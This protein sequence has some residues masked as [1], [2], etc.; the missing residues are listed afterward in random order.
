MLLPAVPTGQDSLKY[1]FGR[2]VLN[3]Y[4]EI[5]DIGRYLRV[6]QEIAE[7]QPFDSFVVESLRI[8]ICFREAVDDLLNILLFSRRLDG[9][10]DLLELV[11]LSL[12]VIPE[13]SNGYN[14]NK[15][16]RHKTYHDIS[17]LLL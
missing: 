14:E 4:L 13:S 11:P 16:N 12:F 17:F 3:G 7:Q 8:V 9:S 6:L 2:C 1:S 15:E 10:N 5:V